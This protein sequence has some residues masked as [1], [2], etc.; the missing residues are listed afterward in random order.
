MEDHEKAADQRSPNT[1]VAVNK[2]EKHNISPKQIIVRG[3]CEY[4][5]STFFVDT[6]SAVSLI[7]KAF[8]DHF[9]LTK[10]A[11]PNDI[12]LKSF[13]SNSIKTYGKL[14]L[15][16]DIAGCT[17]KHSFI[18]TSLVDTTC[19]LGLDFLNEHDI[20]INIT[21]QTL[22]SKNGV[23]HFL[24]QPKL[25]NKKCTVKS[26]ATYCIP[27][28]TVMYIKGKTVTDRCTYSGFLEPKHNMLQSG[29]LVQSGLCLTSDKKIPVKIMNLTDVPVQVYKNKVLG[30]LFPIDNRCDDSYR[31]VVISDD[32]QADI[33]E[34]RVDKN[35]V[36]ADQKW[37]KERLYKELNID[38]IPDIT[39]HEREKLKNIIWRYNH[40]FSSGPAD[41]GE[42]NMYEGEIQL[43]P[44]HTPAWVPAR[45]IPYKMRPIFD[46]HIQDLKAAGVIEECT[47]KSL[48]NSP[49]FLVSKPHSPGKFRFVVDMRAVNLESLPDKYPVPLIGHVADRLGGCK[50]YSSFDLAQGFHQVKYDEKSK[51][52]TSFTACGTRYWFKRLIMGHRSSGA[53]F[54]R[55]ITQLMSNLDFQELIFFLDDLLL[56]SND[57][58]SHLSRLERVLIRFSQ[59]NMKLSPTKCS[60]LKKQINFVGVTINQDGIKIDKGRVRALLELK[61]PQNRKELQKLLGF[62]GFNRRWIKNYASITKCMYNLLRKEVPFKWTKSCDESLKQLKDA[63]SHSITLAIPDLKDELQSY[64][65]VIDGSQDGMGAHLS[66]ILNG[67]RRI[68]AYFSKSVPNYKREIGQTKLEFLTMYH[69]I[70]NFKTYLQGTKFT[71]ITDCRS[72]LNIDTIFSKGSAAERRKIQMLAQYDFVIKHISSEANFVSDFLSRYPFK[73]RFKDASTQSDC[74][75]TECIPTDCTL[76]NEKY[77]VSSKPTVNM[78]ECN[79]DVSE[80][81]T[82]IDEVQSTSVQRSEKTASG[83]ILSHVSEP[84][85]KLDDKINDQ[86]CTRQ[87][88]TE[89]QAATTRHVTK[90]DDDCQDEDVSV[91]ASGSKPAELKEGCTGAVNDSISTSTYREDML[92]PPGFFNPSK[93]SLKTTEVSACRVEEDVQQIA[94]SP[95]TCYCTEKVSSIVEDKQIQEQIE[96]R[97]IPMSEITSLHSTI[98]EAQNTDPVLSVVKRWLCAKKKPNVIQAHRA[99]KDLISYWRQFDL[100]S[101]ENDV[102]MRQWK[103]IHKGD[104]IEDRQLICIP[105]SVQECVLKMCHTSIAVNHPGI[106]ATLDICRRHFYWPRMSFDVEL[107]TK[108]C[109]TCNIAKDPRAYM[110]APRKHVIAHRYNDLIMIDHIEVEKLGL[111]AAGKKYILTM[112]DIWS[113]YVVAGTTNSQTADDTISMIMHKW[114]LWNGIPREIISDNG[115][116]FRSKFYQSVLNA[117]DCKFTYGLPYE[118]KSTAKVERTNRRI[119]QSLRLILAD[120][121]PKT[122]DSYIDY[123]C[124]ALNALKNRTTGYSANFLRF[125]HE[126]NTPMSLLLSNND[127]ED[128]LLPS[129][130]QYDEIAYQ[131]HQAYKDVIRK[132]AANLRATYQRDDMGHNKWTDKPFK[133][134]DSCYIMV[135]CPAHKYSPKWFGPVKVVRAVSDCVYVVQLSPEQQK[136]VNISKMKRCDLKNKFAAKSSSP[137]DSSSSEKVSTTPQLRRS[138]RLQKQVKD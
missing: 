1:Y 18:I 78:T 4:R 86:A 138:E 120:K 119:N 65:L 76:A 52:Y 35:D 92:I 130:N 58:E 88:V 16:V 81:V 9:D 93:R 121:N 103:V 109:R 14:L 102:I 131:K 23:S 90:L 42:C 96:H 40:C 5:D 71:V 2:V 31:S 49:V 6:G 114:V 99:P 89:Q 28:N 68:I 21:E 110:K 98:K 84:V 111:S 69:A 20:N 134:G 124:S 43:K 17:V 101:L 64:Q 91:A 26:T 55:C 127:R 13:T 128:V 11:E 94:E 60:L 12:I 126:L 123:V 34:I 39:D 122:W 132:V 50:Y 73:K 48:W 62:F 100:L 24:K 83:S 56:G 8:T 66:Q 75:Y 7:S 80:T 105:E 29:L 57:V 117:F 41:L 33:H 115:S 54:S 51:P 10:H 32:K 85:Q 45:P 77:K 107:Y 74:I 53:Q 27:P 87:T 125:G 118:S 15:N 59:A 108:A 44:N 129:A 106:N 36:T 112:T 30:K 46:Q 104:K 38:E 70:E 79:S 95:I 133:A 61:A 82:C 25:L 37:T 137:V 72:L 97:P 67:E 22:S 116:G 19:L 136:V 47:Q 63:V 3:L 113:G 135:R